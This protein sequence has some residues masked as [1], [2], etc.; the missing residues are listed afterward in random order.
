MIT[1]YRE[2][3]YN[4]SITTYVVKPRN[5][6]LQRIKGSAVEISYDEMLSVRETGKFKF[7][8]YPDNDS[9]CIETLEDVIL[10]E[11]TIKTR[12]KIRITEFT[13]IK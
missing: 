13:N 2:E 6:D 8:L 7:K 9:K 1:D 10:E 4:D 12:K 11:R 5:R 3:H